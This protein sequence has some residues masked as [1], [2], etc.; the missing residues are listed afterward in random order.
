MLILQL[1][2]IDQVCVIVLHIIRKHGLYKCFRPQKYKNILENITLVRLVI[3][4]FL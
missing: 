1:R 4:W 3:H 2:G